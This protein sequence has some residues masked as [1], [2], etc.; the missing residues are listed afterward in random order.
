MNGMVSWMIAAS[1]S[2]GYHGLFHCNTAHG[3]DARR[4]EGRHHFDIAGA[5]IR[6][7][8]LFALFVTGART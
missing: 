4:L 7:C 8:S 1:L 3:W 5:F 6:S 2:C